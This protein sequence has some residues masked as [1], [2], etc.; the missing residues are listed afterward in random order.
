MIN[1]KKKIVLSHNFYGFS[2][3]SGENTVFLA[4]KDM[5]LQHGHQLIEFVRNSDDIRDKGVFGLVQGACAT[6]WNPFAKAA[7]RRVLD[8]EQPDVIH[9]HNTFPLLSPAIF[10]AARD[11]GA[12]VVLTLHNFRL[13][14]A[15]GIPMRDSLPCIQCLDKKSVIPALRY[16]CY[17]DSRMATLP[18]AAMIGLHRHLGTWRKC[19]DAFVALTAFQKGKMVDAGLPAAKVYIKPQFYPA[20][21]SPVPWQDR[22]AKA[23]Y[24]GRLGEEKGVHF[25]IQ[26][27]AKWG[28]PAPY[29]EIIGDGPWKAR[30]QAQV[31]S[32]C[33]QNK[34]KL[35]GQLSFEA[36][37]KKLANAHLLVLPSL[38][39]EGF[40]MVIRE[41]LALGVPI[42][43]SRIGAIP[44]IVMDHK[45][46]LLF[47]PGDPEDMLRILKSMWQDDEKLST[48]AENA[49]KDFEA[50]YTAEENHRQ[51]MEIYSAAMEHRK[52]RIHNRPA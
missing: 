25:L 31:N 46:G 28:D 13:F 5:L 22:A 27:W 2:A 50:K 47:K 23:M 15:A 1:E 20:P 40:P 4:E 3:P 49:R 9:V 34:I 37:Q 48:M 44:D 41:A 8:A 18:M 24:I 6:P 7:L 21:P 10:H 29:L 32:L 12:A 52:R 45:T 35:S 38:C 33:L 26:A 11:L 30:L 51:L 16:G 42:A 19:V 14:C 17:R 43:A 39:F 36:T